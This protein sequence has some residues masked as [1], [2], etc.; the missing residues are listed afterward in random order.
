MD[1]YFWLSEDGIHQ[2]PMGIHRIYGEYGNGSPTFFGFLEFEWTF[3][4]YAI[5]SLNP[6][7]STWARY[8]CCF[9]SMDQFWLNPRVARVWVLS[10]EEKT[11]KKSLPMSIFQ[12]QISGDLEIPPKIHQ[13]SPKIPKN[14][15]KNPHFGV[16]GRPW[17]PWHPFFIH[18]SETGL[19]TAALRQTRAS[20][21]RDEGTHGDF[22]HG[23]WAR[24]T[25]DTEWILNGY[26]MDTE[27][28][29]NGYLHQHLSSPF[30]H[31]FDGDIHH[32]FIS[33]HGIYAWGY[34]K[35]WR[36]IG[37][38]V[39]RVLDWGIFMDFPERP[40]TTTMGIGLGELSPSGWTV[41][42]NELPGWWF[43]TWLDD[44]S[45]YWECHHPNWL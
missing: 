9:S 26:W 28:I 7:P 43:G 27:W 14:P 15:Q 25:M 35:N 3:G 17:H 41:E 23:G 24:W 42:V 11:H 29:L 10:G 6:K 22:T 36:I 21:D 13:K 20:L 33:F 45:I 38:S 40:G 19:A 31:W 30:L 16:K 8:T 44:F 37:M 1:P 12:S 5:W 4:L 39:T 18:R 32:I 2:N 34:G